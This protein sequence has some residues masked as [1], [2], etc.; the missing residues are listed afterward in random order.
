MKEGIYLTFSSGSHLRTR[1]EQNSEST[2]SKQGRPQGGGG[3]SPPPETERIVVEKSCY[4]PELYKMA[5]VREDEIE[6]G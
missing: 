2:L 4:F 5:K 3:S 6:N 1:E